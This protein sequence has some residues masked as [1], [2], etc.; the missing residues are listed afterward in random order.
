MVR[1]IL[2]CV[3]YLDHANTSHFAAARATTEIDVKID[4]LSKLQAEF[5]AGVEVCGPRLYYE[6]A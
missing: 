1:A 4:A 2:G 6:Y 3:G 5:E